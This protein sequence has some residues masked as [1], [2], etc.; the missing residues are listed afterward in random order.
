MGILDIFNPVL[1]YT[2]KYYDNNYMLYAIIGGVIL[3]LTAVGYIIYRV[4]S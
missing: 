1:D 3:F 2:T 4:F